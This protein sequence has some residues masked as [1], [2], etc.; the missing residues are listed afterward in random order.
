[1]GSKLRHQKRVRNDLPGG[2]RPIQL[3]PSDHQGPCSGGAAFPAPSAL[4]CPEATSTALAGQWVH[5]CLC[6]W[7]P[8]TGRFSINLPNLFS[9]LLLLPVLATPSANKFQKFITCRV[10]NVLLYVS[11]KHHRINIF[12]LKFLVLLFWT[13]MVIVCSDI[14]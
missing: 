2:A 4:S 13:F 5:L 12:F 6:L 7:C 1:M 11:N 14:D 9:S 10:K 3:F 8:S